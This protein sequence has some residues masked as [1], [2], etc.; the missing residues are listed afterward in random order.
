MVL[1]VGTAWA[2]VLVV[3]GLILLLSVPRG[4]WSLGLEAAGGVAAVAA[5][6]FVFMFVVADR[7]FPGRTRKLADWTELVMGAAFVCCAAWALLLILR[8][9]A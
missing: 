9:G 5:G 7:L 4:G 2:G 3:V 8:S 1:L 6:E